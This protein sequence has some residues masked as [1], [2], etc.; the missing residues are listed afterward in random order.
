MAGHPIVH[1]EI[2]AASASAAGTFYNEVFGWKIE[3]DP[4]FNYVQFRSEGGPGGGFVEPGATAPV[5]YKIDRLLVYLNTDDIE[6]S[7]AA[8]EA[9]GGKTVLPKTE[10]P[11]IG[12]WAVFTDPSG[13]HLALYTSVPHAG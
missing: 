13:N 9:H 12:W 3:A 6:A 5:E 4:T 2:P 7:L 11:G 10:I 8:V 1:I